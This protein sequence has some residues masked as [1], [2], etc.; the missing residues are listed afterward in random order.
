MQTA[1]ID[2][3]AC[4][5]FAMLRANNL[6][7]AIISNSRHFLSKLNRPAL[8]FDQ[9]LKLLTDRRV[10][11]DA[12][13]WHSQPRY[14]M[15]MRFNLANSF[16]RNPLHFD[17]V[18]NSTPMKFLQPW[19]LGFVTRDDDFAAYVVRDSVFTA[20][21]DHRSIPLARHP[22]FQAPGLIIDTGMN[23]SAVMTG[24]MKGQAGF[25]F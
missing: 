15:D 6:L 10:V 8:L 19:Q 23:H 7:L 17:S 9:F 12:G 18:R 13:A 4:L 21:L 14:A 5:K 24:L 20:E 25:L 1:A 16:G 2:E 22:S 11:N 3:K